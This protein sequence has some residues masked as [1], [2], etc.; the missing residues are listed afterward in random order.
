MRRETIPT[1]A[2]IHGT[3]SYCGTEDQSLVEPIA[4]RDAFE[5]IISIYTLSEDGKSLVEW[6]KED[7]AMFDHR[8]MDI[9][10]A[11]VLLADILDDGEI[12]RKNFVPATSSN[13]EALDGWEELRQELMHENR[14]F[15]RNRIDNEQLPPLLDQLKLEQDELEFY[16]RWY[17]A[18]IQQTEEGFSV[19]KMGAPPKELASHG[20]ANPVGIPY[21]YLASTPTTAISEV[22]PHTG[23]TASVADF[24]IPNNLKI[25]DLRNPR[26]TFSPFFY[27]FNLQEEKLESLRGWIGLLER[28]GEELTRP[29]LPHAA[30]IHYI[31]SQYLCEF[32]K[33]CGYDGVMYRSSVERE[34][35]NIALF[36]PSQAK[37]GGVTKR[38]VSRVSV[39]IDD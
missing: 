7:W 38:R 20:R 24:Q 33:K 15:P 12:V 30:A 2:K 27:I 6:L 22:R 29:V 16:V 36:N 14:F 1:H 35:V 25:I 34:G 17:R 13:T 4:L 9:A 31:P 11:K 10:N 28:L 32:V 37:V 8:S 19:D 39:E 23:E 3:C 26:K 21:L 18:R 5:Q